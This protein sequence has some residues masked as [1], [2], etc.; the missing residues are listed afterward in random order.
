MHTPATLL[1]LALAFASLDAVA[2]DWPQWRGPDRDGHAAPGPTLA[3][4]PKALRP[5]WKIPIGGGHSG[6][7]WV[8]STVLYLDEDGSHEVAHALDA[9]TGKEL[10][11]AELSA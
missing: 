5:K 3:S 2:Q 10:W 7:V 9:E 8:G 6:P 4:L 1:A 11:R